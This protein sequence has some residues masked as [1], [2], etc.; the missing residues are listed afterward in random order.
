MRA[1]LFIQAL[2]LALPGLLLAHS[3]QPLKVDELAQERRVVHAP[4]PVYP[5]LAIQARI[6]GTVRLAVLIGKDGAVERIRLISGHP[7]LVGAAMDA[8]KQ[9]EY[10]PIVWFGRP[11]KVATTVS[12]RFSLS[13]DDR[14]LR[15]ETLVASAS[16]D[17]AGKPGGE[18][19][20]VYAAAVWN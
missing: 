19:A 2:S 11:M 13:S 1:R 12:L 8:V 10:E 7:F 9:W 3:E 4:A 14:P 6:Q 18:K 15:G 17:T 20:V 16:S 5:K